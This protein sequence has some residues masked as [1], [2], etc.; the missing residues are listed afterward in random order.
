MTIIWDHDDPPRAEILAALIRHG[1]TAEIHL[2][3]WAEVAGL[4]HMR[5]A[6]NLRAPHLLPEAVEAWR[7]Q[8]GLRGRDHG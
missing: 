7:E 8:G 1:T 2:R 4:H 3:V 6:L 5:D